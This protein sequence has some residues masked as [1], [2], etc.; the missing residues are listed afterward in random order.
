[1]PLLEVVEHE[2]Q[3]AGV[4]GGGEGRGVAAGEGVGVLDAGL[5]QTMSVAL[6]TT[7][8]VRGS[9]APG[10]SCSEMMRIARSRFGMNPVGSRCTNQPAKASSRT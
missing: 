2:E 7:A 5:G 9:E 10:G 6:R 4:G 3:Q 8:S 1:M